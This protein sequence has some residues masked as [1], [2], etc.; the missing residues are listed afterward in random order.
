M[1]S[2]L[3]ITPVSP[4]LGARVDGVDLSRELPAETVSEIRRALLKHEV[5]FFEDQDITPEQQRDFA[6]R[7]GRLHVHPIRPSVPGI[8]EVLVMG[9]QPGSES[10]NSIWRSDVT[11]IETPPLGSVLYACEMPRQGGDTIW[12]SMRAA[13]G[14]LSSPMQRFLSGL[15]AE[16]DF[17][18]SYPVDRF[19]AAAAGIER[20]TWTRREHPP[21]RHPVVRTHPETNR[22]G[23]FVNSGFTTRIL[24]LNDNES[25]Q[26]LKMLCDHIQ[27]PEFLVRWKWQPGT[28]AFWDN[29]VTQHYTVNDYLPHRRILRRA[30]ILGDRPF[31]RAR[32]TREMAAE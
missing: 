13:Y 5:L 26:V 18:R 22:D 2:T 28:L 21:V 30:T 16:H 17:A 11:F 7:F 23:L 32:L 9:D 10:D 14:A 29:R 3:R 20:F 1:S 27:K 4:S 8:P 12:S 31:N 15:D 25:E 19:A 24:G 6:A